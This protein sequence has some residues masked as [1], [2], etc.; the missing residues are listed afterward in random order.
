MSEGFNLF[1][2]DDKSNQREVRV[3]YIDPDLGFVNNV[4]RYQANKY[5]E[6]NP[7]TQFIVSNRDKVSYLNINEVNELTID[8]AAPSQ[9]YGVCGDDDTFAAVDISITDEDVCTKRKDRITV[10]FIG[11]GGVGA[12]ANPVVGSDGGIVAIDLIHGGFGYKYPPLVQITDKCS[13]GKGAAAVSTLGSTSSALETYNNPEDFEKLDFSY[14]SDEGINF[15]QIY[16][17][18]YD[19]EGI[20]IG[21]WSPS[22]YAN[23]SEDPINLEIKKYQE[24]LK[25][26]RENWWTTRT[27]DPDSVTAAGGSGKKQVY[28]VS[29]WAWGGEVIKPEPITGL[30]EVPF[31]IR[32]IEESY[33]KLNIKIQ[34][35]SEDGDHQFTLNPR[36]REDKDDEFTVDEQVERYSDVKF[37]FLYDE[38]DGNYYLQTTGSGKAKATLRFESDDSSTDGKAFAPDST[39]EI[40]TDKDRLVFT[41]TNRV[42]KKEKL[43]GTF[44]A[45]NK[46]LILFDSVYSPKVKGD[47]IAWDDDGGAGRT[48]KWDDNAILDIKDIKQ[49]YYT[50]TVTREAAR[51][52]ER[53]LIKKVRANTTYIITALDDRFQIKNQKS[54]IRNGVITREGEITSDDPN[55]IAGVGAITFYTNVFDEQRDEKEEETLVSS[56]RGAFYARERSR[57]GNEQ[58]YDYVYRLDLPDFQTRELITVDDTFMNLH[59]VSPVPKSDAVKSANVGRTYSMRWREYFPYG[60]KYI[61][62]GIADTDSFLTLQKSGS[63]NPVI[64]SWA[65]ERINFSGYDSRCDIITPRERSVELSEGFYTISL[66]LLNSGPGEYAQLGGGKNKDIWDSR[67]HKDRATNR[68]QDKKVPLYRVNP[69]NKNNADF[70][71]TYGISPI[72]PA[73]VERDIEILK[74][75]ALKELEA[76]GARFIYEN[77]KVFLKVTG[78]GKVRVGFE[79]FIKDDP[80]VSGLAITEARIECDGEDIRI[81]RGR[82][83]DGGTYESGEWRYNDIKY[84]IGEFSSGKKYEVKLLGG[85]RNTGIGVKERRKV[86]IDDNIQNGYDRNAEL[87][88]TSVK[89]L[90]VPVDKITTD[91]YAGSYN[92]QWDNLK[93]K[94]NG[95]YTFI[96]EADYEA[97]VEISDK[98]GNRINENRYRQTFE[99]KDKQNISRDLELKKGDYRISVTLTQFPGDIIKNFNAMA[100]GLKITTQITAA[101]EIELNNQSW[102]ENPMGVALTIDAPEPPVPVENAPIQIG[103][104]ANNPLWSTRFEPREPEDRWYPVYNGKDDGIS[105]GRGAVTTDNDIRILGYNPEGQNNL[106]WSDFM[107]RYAVSPVKPSGAESSARV[108]DANSRIVW[109]VMI[110]YDG[111]YGV[112]G[113]YSGAN[114]TITLSGPPVPGGSQTFNLQNSNS[115]NG[116]KDLKID[117]LEL[118]GSNEGEASRMQ[119]EVFVEN[120]QIGSLRTVEDKIF[121]TSDW[122]DSIKD[123][124]GDPIEEAIICHAGGG[125]GGKK[126]GRQE[127]VGRVIIGKGGSGGEG[128]SDEERG[129]GANGGGAGLRDGRH[130]RSGKGDS[131]DGG[132]GASFDGDEIGSN[133]EVRSGGDDTR[134]FDTSG[135]TQPK[136]QGGNGARHGGGGG[137]SRGGGDSGN[138]GDGGVRLTW[139][140]T[141]KSIEFNRPGTYTAIVPRSSPGRD[142]ITSVKMVCIGGGGSG[143]S[144]KS[145]GK[146]VDELV[147]TAEVTIPKVTPF[148]F[149]TEYG[150]EFG[151]EVR[152]EIK[153]VDVKKKIRKVSGGGGSGGAYARNKV[154]LPAGAVLEVVVG[155]G[156]NAPREG[157][158]ADGQDSY[159]RVLETTLKPRFVSIDTNTGEILDGDVIEKRIPEGYEGVVYK[160]PPIA[161]YTKGRN[162]QGM[163]PLISPFLP[164]GTLDLS[165]SGKVSEFVWKDFNFPETE[166]YIF[167]AIADETLEV[168]IGDSL[169]KDNRVMKVSVEQGVKRVT[170]K[171]TRGD[172]KITLRLK[173]SSQE[174][175]NY[176]LNPMFAGFRIY[177][178]VVEQLS[179]DKRSWR[180][181]PVGVSAVIIPPPCEKELSG[182]GVV[183]DVDMTLPGNGFSAPAG[184]GYPVSLEIVDIE[185]VEPG[186]NYSVGDPIEISFPGIGPIIIPPFFPGELDDG[187]DSDDPGPGTPPPDD[188]G[189]PDG[190]DPDDDPDGLF[191]EGDGAPP[192]VPETEPPRFTDP[193]DPGPPDDD[194]PTGETLAPPPPV[195][196]DFDSF[197]RVVNVGVP[198]PIPI[199]PNN[200]RIRILSQTGINA[201][202]RPKIGVVRDPLGVS[203]EN[204]IQVTD[205]VGLKQTGYIDGRPYYGQVFTRNGI[206]YAGVYRTVGELVQVYNTLQESIDRQV[207]TPPSAIIRQGTDITTNDPRLNIPGT[208]E[209]LE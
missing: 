1:E 117:T 184:A 69:S 147:G 109:D 23:F 75:D 34:F 193:E 126:N 167:E 43:S 4:S 12:Q 199:P 137:G 203:P 103:R 176:N 112:Q 10:D 26:D 88:I 3:G 132:F 164:N 82:I 128:Q 181:N 119:V 160:G 61:F 59:A 131:L 201:V 102:D 145:P 191:D 65:L 192:D 76:L 44:T 155:G 64:D 173:N 19:E 170:R 135:L 187:D 35:T 72:A 41:N 20:V 60:G 116:I 32:N 55:S 178:E 111:T 38:V 33:S 183:T 127:K 120:D 28:N 48:G 107:N 58:K 92:F 101:E 121:D 85:G 166:K 165:V 118:F 7:G 162:A 153:T 174:G 98:K 86:G 70:I 198:V 182:N 204:L 52:F 89:A 136:D 13:I 169:D 11:G 140:S 14:G 9:N 115:G 74:R 53:V 208:P 138:G 206:K 79:L 110:P 108:P 25:R 113:T 163:G 144:D 8:T 194:R 81:R 95:I 148:E 129:E 105:G 21:P 202:L 195:T 209:T 31:E 46:Y 2:L 161:S 134:I 197:G 141:G 152:N 45:G 172:K 158:S 36:F 177:R 196:L 99:I 40:E 186:I 139:G 179:I 68:K 66:D 175:I 47:E 150:T 114:G 15:P 24:E 104:C 71:N 130:A 159:V 6:L 190:L 56:S 30:V 77:D 57:I 207:T 185:V 188:P 62:R 91:N 78:N 142:D 97:L 73:T 42:D 123:I 93:I 54:I 37:T 27:S 50:E 87:S 154:K 96:M 200:P 133:N 106:E 16:G 171:V 205:L 151:V 124:T 84:G 157:G 83:G 122:I 39:V 22:D 94:D 80:D 180:E 18:R 143:H 156:G 146:E 90:E 189:E 5:A 100:F 168:F 63:A 67:E 51:Q 29:H 149:Q 125:F 17:S 49:L